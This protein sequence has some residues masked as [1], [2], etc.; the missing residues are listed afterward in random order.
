VLSIPADRP[1]IRIEHVLSTFSMAGAPLPQGMGGTNG[2]GQLHFV[3]GTGTP[4]YLASARTTPIRPTVDVATSAGS[5]ALSWVAF[6]GGATCTWSDQTILNVF[7]TRLTLNEGVQPTL[8]VTGGTL[9]GLGAKSGQMSLVFDAALP[10][11][12]LPTAAAR[13]AAGRSP[14]ARRPRGSRRSRRAS[15]TRAAARGA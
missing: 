15:R 5:R 9:G 10:A 2:F 12:V 8:T 7:G 14:T 13:T 11:A 6:C 3:D 4:L 1:N